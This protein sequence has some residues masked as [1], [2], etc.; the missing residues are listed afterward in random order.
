MAGTT[1]AKRAPRKAVPAK[2]AA[3]KAVPSKPGTASGAPRVVLNLDTLSKA[4]AFPGL[5]LPKVP[6]TFLQIGV[7]YE[8]SDPRDSDWKQALELAGNPFMLMRTAL[9]G[10]EEP[11]DDPTAAEIRLCRERYGLLPD[12]PTRG[13]PEADEELLL[14]PDGITPALIDR[15][16]ASELPTWKLNA[17][18]QGWHEHYKIDLTDGKGILG[19]LLGQRD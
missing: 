9:V 17:L 7:Q 19:A 15:F 18:F 13:T 1:P 12:P 11:I 8:L 4:K 14:F 3:L 2:R 6:F 10:A 5:Q 16:V